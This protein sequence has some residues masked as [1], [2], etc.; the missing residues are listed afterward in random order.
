MNDYLN[1]R[2]LDRMKSGGFVDAQDYK[3]NGFLK[4]LCENYHAVNNTLYFLKPITAIVFHG[5]T[6]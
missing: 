5:F 1:L 2:W 3:A 4:I 6:D